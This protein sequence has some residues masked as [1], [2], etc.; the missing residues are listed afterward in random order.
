MNLNLADTV[1]TQGN[2]YYNKRLLSQSDPGRSYRDKVSR[3][4]GNFKL[5]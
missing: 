5:D 1:S 3:Y 2:Y 4:S